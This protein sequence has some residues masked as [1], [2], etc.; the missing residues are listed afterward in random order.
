MGT[1]RISSKTK[2][3]QRDQKRETQLARKKLD[4]ARTALRERLGVIDTLDTSIFSHMVDTAIKKSKTQL[5]VI[6]KTDIPLLMDLAK[7]ELRMEVAFRTP[8]EHGFES[9]SKYKLPK[10]TA[11]EIQKIADVHPIAMR[12]FLDR[13]GQKA[14]LRE[15]QRLYGPV[16]LALSDEV[17]EFAIQKRLVKRS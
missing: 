1:K 7:R 13:N 15:F 12:N 2:S 4:A 8:E 14:N 16:L 17:H 3:L 5:G 10:Q 11:R 6:T 9:E